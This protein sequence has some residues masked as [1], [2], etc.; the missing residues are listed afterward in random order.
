MTAEFTERLAQTECR[1]RLVS[2]E[3]DQLK[4]NLSAAQAK[5]K[6]SKKQADEDSTSSLPSSSS[7]DL[8]SLKL[9]GFMSHEPVTIFHVIGPLIVWS[10]TTS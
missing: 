3:R 5:L 6:P 9:V 10:Y 8:I 4:L 1:L 7:A 2:R